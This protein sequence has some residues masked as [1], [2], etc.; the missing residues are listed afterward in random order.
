MRWN[1]DSYHL[2]LE[3]ILEQNVEIFSKNM[4]AVQKFPLS[5]YMAAITNQSQSERDKGVL[6]KLLK[7]RT[8]SIVHFTVRN[9]YGIYNSFCN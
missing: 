4:E 6:L 7:N 8:I 9:G 5:F 2:S 1:L 3:F